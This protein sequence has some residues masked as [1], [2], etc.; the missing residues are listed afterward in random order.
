MDVPIQRG[1][2]KG[3]K[4]IVVQ[5][6]KTKNLKYSTQR[7]FIVKTTTSKWYLFHLIKGTILNSFF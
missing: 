5:V 6:K 3:N 1:F 4:K 7:G 2:N